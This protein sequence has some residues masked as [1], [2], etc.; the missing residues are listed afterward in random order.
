VDITE[1]PQQFPRG[2]WRP[3]VCGTAESAKANL[4]P[5]ARHSSRLT[6]AKFRLRNAIFV[7]KGGLGPLDGARVTV[8]GTGAVELVSGGFA[9]GDVQDVI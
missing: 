9:V 7:E 5:F 8:D 4:A 6:L 3:T 1:Q 2:L